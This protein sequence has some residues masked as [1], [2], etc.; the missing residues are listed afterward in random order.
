MCSHCFIFI[1]C[2]NKI[3]SYFIVLQ[4]EATSSDRFSQF[5]QT[6]GARLTMSTP[7]GN[8]LPH[9]SEHLASVR[10]HHEQLNEHM[11]ATGETDAG[12]ASRSLM[13]TNLRS[14]LQDL[15]QITS[16]LRTRLV[17]PHD[18]HRRPEADDF[19]LSAP[20][21][22]HG[23]EESAE[24]ASEE[25]PLTSQDRPMSDTSFSR[26]LQHA[27]NMLQVADQLIANM[28]DPDITRQDGGH[29]I[30]P[31]RACSHGFRVDKHSKFLSKS[32]RTCAQRY[33]VERNHR[34]SG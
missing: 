12:Q 30:Q 27:Q 31:V 13:F 28:N 4:T 14:Q 5:L 15:D 10:R 25:K 3:Y 20:L 9:Y 22:S 1:S 23:E 7:L 18:A 16:A 33:D 19:T 11:S 32:C 26:T 34:L 8:Q 6:A 21:A 24:F 2:L 17:Q 29:Q